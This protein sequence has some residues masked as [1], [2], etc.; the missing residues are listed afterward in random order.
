[1]VSG[2]KIRETH[3]AL[4][5]G[6]DTWLCRMTK[7]WIKNRKKRPQSMEW[8]RVKRQQIMLVVCLEWWGKRITKKELVLNMLNHPKGPCLICF[9]NEMYYVSFI[10]R[11]TRQSREITREYKIEKKHI[12]SPNT[13]KRKMRK[14]KIMILKKNKRKGKIKK[15]REKTHSTVVGN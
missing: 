6:I 14:L 7:L 3:L 4:L 5:V 15:T 11:R 1:M 10:N 13:M 12:T 9:F 2:W 8:N